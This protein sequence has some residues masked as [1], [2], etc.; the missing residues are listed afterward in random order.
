MTFGLLGILSYAIIGTINALKQSNRST[1]LVYI[2]IILMTI[3]FWSKYLLYRFFDYPALLIVPIS[4]TIFVLYI[5]KGDKSNWRLSLVLIAYLFLSIPLFGFNLKSPVDYIPYYWYDRLRAESSIEVELPYS[6]EFAE[7]KQISDRAHDL[8]K[9][10]DYYSASTLFKEA[11]NIEPNNLDL[12]FNQA[13][14]LATINQLENAILLLDTAILF[15]ST[16]PYF[17]SN[18][19]LLQHKIGNYNLSL[20]DYNKAIELDSLQPVFYANLAI[21]YNDLGEDS[22][23]CYCIRK[24]EELGLHI[25]QYKYLKSLKRKKCSRY[26]R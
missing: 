20:D 23:I 8:M 13:H 26:Y 16:V 3:T 5:F 25:R 2:F 24:S 10:G 21:L 6:F 11:R 1:T 22:L 18:R 4:L 9:E 14:V 17:Y 19:A 12:I 7:T 15:D